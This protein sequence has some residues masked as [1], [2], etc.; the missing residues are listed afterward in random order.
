MP[1]DFT[2]WCLLW[3][4]PST[5]AYRVLV[6]VF[7]ECNVDQVSLAPWSNLGEANDSRRHKSVMA[8]AANIVRIDSSSL[9]LL[10]GRKKLRIWQ[11]NFVFHVAIRRA[12][13]GFYTTTFEAAAKPKQRCT[14]RVRR[15]GDQKKDKMRVGC[16]HLDDAALYI[17]YANFKHVSVQKSCTLCSQIIESA[18]SVR[19]DKM[20]C[21]GTKS[22]RDTAPLL[23]CHGENSPWQSSTWRHVVRELGRQWAT[24]P[25]TLP[26]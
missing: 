20:V 5:F 26:V 23:N 15:T 13:A 16:K 6:S 14:I 25:W 17:L 11:T 18:D 1:C 4:S 24:R 19:Q 2:A 10:V 9:S 21:Q 7:R 12:K 22:L 3:S 8:V